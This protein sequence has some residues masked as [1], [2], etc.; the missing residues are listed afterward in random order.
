MPQRPWT[1]EAIELSRGRR[2]VW[3]T[4]DWFAD[5]DFGQS[6][7]NARRRDNNPKVAVNQDVGQHRFGKSGAARKCWPGG[8]LPTRDLGRKS[9]RVAA[10]EKKVQRE[11]ENKAHHDKQREKLNANDE[12]KVVLVRNKHSAGVWQ[13]SPDFRVMMGGKK[14]QDL[15][16]HGE[17]GSIDRVRPY[18]RFE[19]E[20]PPSRKDPAQIRVER[21]AAAVAREVD[22]FHYW[23]DRDYE[24]PWNWSLQRGKAAVFPRE[25][26]GHGPIKYERKLGPSYRARWPQKAY[27]HRAAIPAAVRA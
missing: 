12:R 13:S 11:R 5:K 4:H 15:L 19:E 18:P 25:G 26:H 7:A 23:C 10:E 21:E 6:A 14:E 1:A 27:P 2:K 17:V 24:S 8:G 16:P 20:K 22:G 3:P 9:E